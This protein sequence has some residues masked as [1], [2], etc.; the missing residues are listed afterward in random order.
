MQTHKKRNRGRIKTALGITGAMAGATLTG[1]ALIGA[2]PQKAAEPARMSAIDFP[3]TTLRTT[4]KMQ[5][6]VTNVVADA[7]DTLPGCRAVVRLFDNEG[8]VIETSTSM[9]ERGKTIQVVQDAPDTR[10]QG[11]RG[12]LLVSEGRC[13]NSVIVSME[14]IDTTSGQVRAVIAPS[15]SHRTTQIVNNPPDTE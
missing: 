14:I 6:N 12:E 2:S 3:F 15:T 4:Q 11:V 13:R 5:L 1:A 8:N 9:V 10:T 7:P